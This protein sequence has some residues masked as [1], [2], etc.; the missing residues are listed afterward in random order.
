M[1]NRKFYLPESSH[2][3]DEN[4]HLLS[5]N[6]DDQGSFCSKSGTISVRGFELLNGKQSILISPNDTLLNSYLP[7]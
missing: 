3:W 6:W 5:H 2:F 1:F 7:R 4:I